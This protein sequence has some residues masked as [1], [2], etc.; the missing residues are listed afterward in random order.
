MFKEL[1]DTELVRLGGGGGGGGGGGS[2]G[3]GG[4]E[5]GGGYAGRLGDLCVVIGAVVD[6]VSVCIL[7]GGLGDV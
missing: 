2:D 5:G 6:E 1:L 4:C 3:G 7:R